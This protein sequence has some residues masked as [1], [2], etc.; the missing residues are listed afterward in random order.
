MKLETELALISKQR[1]CISQK[2]WWRR[3]LTKYSYR[4][5]PTYHVVALR[6]WQFSKQ[7][8]KCW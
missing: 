6:P 1:E 7:L 3:V 2:A 4:N 8:P 5:S